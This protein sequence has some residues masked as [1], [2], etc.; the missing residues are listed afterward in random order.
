MI[1]LCPRQRA[2][3]TDLKWM[4]QSS[5]SSL[6]AGCVFSKKIFANPDPTGNL[7]T[8]E[9]GASKKATKSLTA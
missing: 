4:P 9:T 5:C 1:L 6:H 7:K 2:N 8:L 3:K